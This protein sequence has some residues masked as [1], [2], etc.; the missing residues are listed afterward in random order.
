MLLAAIVVVDQELPMHSAY[1][2]RLGPPTGDQRSITIHII[3]G[4]KAHTFTCAFQLE[5][6]LNAFMVRMRQFLLRQR[7]LQHWCQE[8]EDKGGIPDLLVSDM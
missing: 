3:R 2:H 8:V 6:D 5:E 7:I 4:G 1:L